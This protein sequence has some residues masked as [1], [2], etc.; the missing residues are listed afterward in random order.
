MV[1]SFLAFKQVEGWYNE[2]AVGALRRDQAMEYVR[3]NDCVSLEK[4]TLHSL[5]LLHIRNVKG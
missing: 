2:A 3:A 4:S 1:L 5:S